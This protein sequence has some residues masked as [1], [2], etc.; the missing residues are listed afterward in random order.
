MNRL[1]PP[2]LMLFSVGATVGALLGAVVVVVVV[3][4]VV[5]VLGSFSPPVPHA[6]RPPRVIS[7]ARPAAAAR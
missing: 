2:G 4:V 5:G 3:V 1:P 6:V 7:A